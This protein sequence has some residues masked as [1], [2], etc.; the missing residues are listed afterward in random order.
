MKNKKIHKY[1][2]DYYISKYS[3]TRNKSE[4]LFMS[5][6]YFIPR[7][8][9]PGISILDFG[10]AA[11]G[12]SQILAEYYDDI[13]YHGV[14]ISSE[15][16]DRAR[17][18]YPDKFFTHIDFDNSLIELDNIKFDLV[19][20][21]GVT[22]HAPDYQKILKKLW[23]LTSHS[24]IFDMRLKIH[25]EEILS[26]DLSYSLNPGGIK[27]YYI[28]A[29]MFHFIKFL[30]SSHNSIPKSIEIIGYIAKPN[31]YTVIPDDI[32]DVYMCGFGLVKSERADNSHTN[33]YI[34]MPKQVFQQNSKNFNN[35]STVTLHHLV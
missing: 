12:F 19:Q 21:W 25:G 4:D 29:N 35:L 17:L 11:G 27:Y 2:S 9:K 8:L 24:L 23:D 22:V 13:K 7:Y 30:I 16:I 26:K 10:C 5:E 15:M 14:D 33:I 6:R 31:E 32:T 28:V 3:N 20:S 18:S 34:N 1:S